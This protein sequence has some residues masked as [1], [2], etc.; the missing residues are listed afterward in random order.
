MQGQGNNLKTD[1][2]VL[3]VVKFELG[4]SLSDTI[5]FRK[6]DISEELAIDFCKR[7]NL[8]INVYPT[9]VDA[10]NQ[11]YKTVQALN[12]KEEM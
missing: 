10:L 3:F 12:E 9:I 1:N 7:N 5:E 8:G 6:Y 4:E 2:E 11:K